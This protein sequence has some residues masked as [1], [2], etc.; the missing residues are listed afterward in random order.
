MKR[1]SWVLAVAIGLTIGACGGGGDDSGDLGED[2]FGGVGESSDDAEP[3]DQGSGGATEIG[4]VTQTAD[5]S[6]GWVEV[7]GERYEFSAFG[8]T[9]YS[10][11]LLEDR[12]T[13][14][15]QQ[16]TAGHDLTLQGSVLNGQ[17]TANLTFVPEGETQV[18]Y[19][20]TIGFDPGRFGIGEEAVSYEGTV[21]RVEDFDVQNTQEM[22]AVIAV[23][24]APP[25]GVP[26]AEVGGESFT[27]PLSGAS[28]LECMVSD[29]LVQVLIGQS[30]PEFRQLQIDIQDNGG[31]LFGAAHVSTDEGT[32]TSFVPPDGTG[33]TIEGAGINYEGTF[34]APSGEELEGVVSVTCG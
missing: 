10:C 34:T 22:Q 24:C 25:G 23:N 27:F 12:I 5:P 26:T 13:V 2:V 9:H 8:S 14:N 6:S 3:E 18:N 1:A 33:L 28:S 20:A 21:A 16:T 30:Q 11:E 32:F 17:W 15:F 19:G 29:E 31:E 4:P 7:D